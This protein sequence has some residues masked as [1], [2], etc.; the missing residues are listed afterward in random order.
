M[1]PDMSF[2]KA[3]AKFD[4]EFSSRD[5]A[6]LLRKKFVFHGTCRDFLYVC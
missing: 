4:P 3:D 2:I 1:L 6:P 5:P